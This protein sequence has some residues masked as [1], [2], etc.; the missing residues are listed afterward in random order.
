ML[1]FDFIV[2][3]IKSHCKSLNKT[4]AEKVNLRGSD[5]EAINVGSGID[6]VIL[7]L[8]FNFALII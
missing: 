4:Q 5:C 8:L 1:G 7:L 3:I 6:A 2:L